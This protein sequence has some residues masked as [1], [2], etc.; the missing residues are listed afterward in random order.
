M[1]LWN[2][3][4]GASRTLLGHTNP[5]TAVA[6][7]PSGKTIA[8][9]SADHTVRIWDAPSGQEK[10]APLKH[11]DQ[12]NS[13][14]Y[15]PDGNLLATG[16][17]KGG[18]RLWILNSTA[19]PRTLR[20]EGAPVTGIAFSPDGKLLATGGND[21]VVSVWNLSNSQKTDRDVRDSGFPGSVKSL[22]F[23][24]F[25]GQTKL[26]VCG[27]SV[28][29]FDVS[30]AGKLNPATVKNVA[31]LGASSIAV[32]RSGE[33]F[34]TGG[35]YGDT[36]IWN[37]DGVE[38]L[39]LSGPY[40]PVLSVTFLSDTTLASGSSDGTARL[41]DLRPQLNRTVDSALS[42]SVLQVEFAA[43]GDTAGSLDDDGAINLWDTRSLKQLGTIGA[44]PEKAT[45]LAF[46]PSQRI[47][48][49][50]AA[51]GTIKL[52][53]IDDHR[54]AGILPA[55]SAATIVSLLFSPDG[56]TLVAGDRNG[57]LLI[58]ETADTTSPRLLKKIEL[59]HQ[60]PMIPLAFSPDGN[61]LAA[62]DREAVKLWNAHNWQLNEKE[63]S[64]RFSDVIKLSFSGDSQTLLI[65]ADS[66]VK[67]WDT[68]REPLEP[69]AGERNCKDASG[70]EVECSVYPIVRDITDAT[71]SHD[72]QTIATGSL[73]GTVK[74]WDASTRRELTTL[75][76][77]AKT[78]VVLDN[79]ISSL[80]FS[81]D[82]RMLLVGSANGS[83]LLWHG[84]SD[85]DVEMQRSQPRAAI[86]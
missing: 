44:K 21:F 30:D 46:S 7:D 15:S 25:K 66:S 32:S 19:E 17:A 28:L 18:V 6:Y 11:P 79:F 53:K 80:V 16:D 50:G 76:Q 47:L 29:I 4:T 23:A 9:A 51:N 3:A 33:T 74:L 70:I 52:W 49:S 2:T 48:A 55:A 35:T 42:T 8:T 5:V 73:N 34:A 10:R 39:T 13:V 77:S 36:T 83:L 37:A 61:T 31:A 40:D 1:R 86:R 59:G 67:T 12:V 45:A 72:G 68:T 71:F 58:W 22:A 75:K 24:N 20:V 84:A 43:N 69:P 81:P 26:L 41:W 57:T 27:G 54:A 82:D 56:K 65:V 62:G 63:F 78:G 14:V 60:T 64:T 38:L 85:G